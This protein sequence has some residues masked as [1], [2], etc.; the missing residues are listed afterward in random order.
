MLFLASIMITFFH[1][2]HHH[3]GITSNNLYNLFN[4]LGLL[5]PLDLEDP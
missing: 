4:S 1:H 5:D 3:P 2:H